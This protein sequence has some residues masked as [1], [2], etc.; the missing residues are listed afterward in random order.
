VTTHFEMSGVAETLLL[1][2]VEC[3]H[4]HMGFNLAATFVKV[5]KDFGISDKVQSK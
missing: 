5:L 2:I 3:A 1:D 4:L